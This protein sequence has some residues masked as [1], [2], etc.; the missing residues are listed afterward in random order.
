MVCDVIHDYKW[1]YNPD[2]ANDTLTKE[3]LL[4]KQ[5]SF[6]FIY[7]LLEAM[8]ITVG[9]YFILFY[10]NMLSEEYKY[11]NYNWK[12]VIYAMLMLLATW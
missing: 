11:T 10:Q 2:A 9:S 3:I 8:S 5:A 4:E 6:N 1:L 12:F 7:L